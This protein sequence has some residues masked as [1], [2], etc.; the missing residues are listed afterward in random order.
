MQ[1]AGGDLQVLCAKGA[2]ALSTFKLSRLQTSI[3]EL[4]GLSL[5]SLQSRFC[6]FLSTDLSSELQNQI[7]DILGLV[8]AELVQKSA[9]FSDSSILVLPRLGTTSPWSTKA[10]EILHRCGF[11]GVGRIERGIVWNFQADQALSDSQRRQFELL[12][13]DRMTESVIFSADQIPLIF[14]HSSRKQTT[15]INVMDD[16]VEAL[17]S[18]N[19][20]MGLALSESELEYLN[21]WCVKE[22]RN[23]TETELMMFSQVNSEH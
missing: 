23:P 5:Q 8:E 18:A 3:D 6:Y 9:L 20:K 15:A 13:M 12:L 22:G 17:R 21:H 2:P 10:T 14:K 11:V 4:A 16:G 7:D 1:N 19:R